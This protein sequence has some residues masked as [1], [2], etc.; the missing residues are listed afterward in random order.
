ML[1]KHKADIEANKEFEY[2]LD[3][4]HD[5]RIPITN[6]FVTNCLKCNFTCH[7]PC[8]IAHDEDKHGC[9]AMRGS[10][11]SARCEVCPGSC[12]WRDHYNKN[13]RI[14]TVKKRVIKT[15]SDLKSKYNCAIKGKTKVESMVANITE[16]LEYVHDQILN[17][18]KKTQ[19]C[20]QRLDEIALKPN[21]LTEK[22]YIE[23]LIKSEER[24]AK[25]GFQ[26]RI[27]FYQDAL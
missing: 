7:Y 13:Y 23:L 20:L 27:A 17:R 22:E 8:G 6:K 1:L 5:E 24:E 11:E 9:A 16:A 26:D 4:D 14:V 12:H 25:D 19:E 18:V 3:E 15:S 21:P 10:G 2:P